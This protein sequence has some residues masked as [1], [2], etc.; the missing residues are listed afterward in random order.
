MSINRPV[1]P[2][3]IRAF[4]S[5]RVLLPMVWIHRGSS[6]PLWSMD[7][8]MSIGVES[9]GLCG[10]SWGMAFSVF[11]SSMD[12]CGV[13]ISLVDPTVLVSSTENLL[14]EWGMGFTI[15][16]PENLSLSQAL[17]LARPFLQPPSRPSPLLWLRPRGS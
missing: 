9:G 8:Q 1:A 6:I 7:E 4:I 5:S 2:E 11:G 16:L 13:N 14:V 12:D 10:D 3:S 17:W 15:D